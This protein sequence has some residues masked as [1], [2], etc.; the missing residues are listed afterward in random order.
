MTGQAL[1]YNPDTQRRLG[2]KFIMDC[3]ALLASA[4]ANQDQFR[5]IVQAAACAAMKL[6]ASC[7]NIYEMSCASRRQL[8]AG[9]TSTS[10]QVTFPDGYTGDK[11]TAINGLIALANSP[12]GFSSIFGALLNAYGV[13]G[14]SGFTVAAPSNSSGDDDKKKKLAIGLGVGLGVGIPLLL[15]I[16]FLIFYRSKRT[17]NQVV[18]PGSQA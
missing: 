9:S 10:N 16:A 12:G 13:T 14:V 18:S 11:D 6:A 1:S 2:L 5:R 7:D 3:N 15:A 8:L 4:K 17:A